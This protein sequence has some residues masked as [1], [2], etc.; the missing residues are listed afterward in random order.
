MKKILLSLPVILLVAAGCNSS[1]PAAEQN[2][3]D[4]TTTQQPNNQADNLKTYT[5]TQYNFEFKYPSDWSLATINTG[6][7]YD[8]SKPYILFWAGNTLD[9]PCQDMGCPPKSGDRDELT[10]GDTFEGAPPLNPWYKILRVRGNKWVSIQLTDVNKK[11]ATE[12]ECQNYLKTI[13]F[14]QKAKLQGSQYQTYNEFL[15]LIFSIAL[16]K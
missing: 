4:N 9:A 8:A 14:K 7:G 10:K 15:D 1:Q 2:Q 6:S 16:N 13:P 12:T 5:N 11:C 3:P